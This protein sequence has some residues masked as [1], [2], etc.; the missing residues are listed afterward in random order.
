V[1]QDG[2]IRV[3][4]ER[5]G[6]EQIALIVEDDGPGIPD[7]LSGRIFEPFFTTRPPG[8]GTGLGLSLCYTFVE[9]HGG[10]IWEEGKA[11][12]GARFVIELPLRHPTQLR[13]RALSYPK[14]AE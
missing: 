3:F 12:D 7:D 1:E 8:E 5:R 11:G 2:E 4:T 9:Q 14:P 13:E 6:T 10:R